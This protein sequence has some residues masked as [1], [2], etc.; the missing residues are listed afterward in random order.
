MEGVLIRMIYFW[1][2][3]G[4]GDEE[5]IDVGAVANYMLRKRAA[6]RMNKTLNAQP[7]KMPR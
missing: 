6:L 2:K 4:L 3:A 5:R 7:K 1:Y